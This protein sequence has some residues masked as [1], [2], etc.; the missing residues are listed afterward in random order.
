MSF[1]QTGT[2][3]FTIRP[4][5][6]KMLAFQTVKGPVFARVVKHPGIPKRSFLPSEARSLALAGE[7]IANIERELAPEVGRDGA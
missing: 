3:P 4:K 7:V 5:N 1:H 6:K 2:G